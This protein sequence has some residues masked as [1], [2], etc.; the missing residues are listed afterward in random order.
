METRQTKP[1]TSLSRVPTL[2][3]ALIEWKHRCRG[4]GRC[5]SVD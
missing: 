5:R 2:L 1:E 3:G 4:S